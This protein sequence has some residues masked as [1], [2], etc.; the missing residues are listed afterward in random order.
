[1]F[2]SRYIAH[3]CLWIFLLLLS[4]PAPA[5]MADTVQIA[6]ASDL[7]YCLEELDRLFIAQHP[8]TDLKVST[9][10]SGNFAA[11]INQGA[12]FDVFLSADISY[13]QQLIDAGFADK[14]SLVTYATGRLALWTMNPQ[15]DPGKGFAVLENPVIRH[16]AIANPEHAPYGK[17]A[18]A[19]LEKAGLW[20][21]VSGRIV[22]GENISQAAQYVETGNADIG[23]VAWSLLKS[24][25]MQGKGKAWLL[26]LDAFPRLQQA[27]VLTRK[28]AASPL[29]RQ[30]QQ[31]LRSPEAKTVF[32]RYGFT[33]PE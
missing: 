12:P 9:G 22:F 24:P 15:L 7:A 16:I 31:F 26:P 27:A 28:G 23:F 13:P 29:A 20:Q 8:D 3:N 33:L 30:Y 17:A 1:M 11:Q 14:D 5:A 21:T 4:L 19:A 32:E 25:K 6:A 2:L 10:S 18:K